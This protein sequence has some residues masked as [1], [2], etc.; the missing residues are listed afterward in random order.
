MRLEHNKEKNGPVDLHR[1]SREKQN[2]LDR[3]V[4]GGW[5]GHLPAPLVRGRYSTSGYVHVHIEH[6]HPTGIAELSNCLFSMQGPGGLQLSLTKIL[7]FNSPNLCCKVLSWARKHSLELF[8]SFC[9]QQPMLSALGRELAR[10]QSWSALSSA[11][12]CNGWSEF[13]VGQ[14]AFASVNMSF[15][16]FFF[17]SQD[18]VLHKRYCK[19]GPQSYLL[20]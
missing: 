11:P 8:Q 5:E 19:F 6:N 3:R 9:Q 18:V 17:S 14:N 20:L 2:H 16:F 10:G 13:K 1:A 15:F 4:S 7:D 12:S